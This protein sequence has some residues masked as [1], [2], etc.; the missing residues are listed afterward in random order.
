MLK[1]LGRWWSSGSAER[2]A[3]SAE[4]DHVLMREVMR[5]E[6]VRIK[7]LIATTVLLLV[8]LW[9]VDLIA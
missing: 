7:A 1:M 3:M 6:L 5:T 2:P 9:A 8:V 4:F